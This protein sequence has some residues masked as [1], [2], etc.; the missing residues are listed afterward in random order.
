MNRN[1]NTRII[2]LVVLVVLAFGAAVST[3]LSWQKEKD[4]RI[5]LEAQVDDLQKRKKDLEMTLDAT[6]KEVVILKDKLS[7][8][9]A[10]LLSLVSQFESEKSERQRVSKE[11]DEV[12]A[13]LNS[14]N[15]LKS[16]IEIELN[17]TKKELSEAKAKFSDL[18]KAKQKL[19]EKVKEFESSSDKVELGKIIISP[20]K[21]DKF[22][23]Q[24]LTL[25]KE[26]NFIVINLGQKDGFKTSDVFF[27]NDSKGV[28]LGKGYIEEA[29]EAMS[30]L[31]FTERDI[32]GKLKEGDNL[33]LKVEQ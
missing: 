7:E 2:F 1:G 22:Q 8:S 20:K 5:G 29:K 14:M 10:D 16:K 17:Q 13:D 33:I 25:N 26:Y 23:A 11:L 28:S 30:V 3:F 9:E 6:R 32:V 19:E 12:K 4:K 18:V 15:N 31:S 21:T 24:I 27:I